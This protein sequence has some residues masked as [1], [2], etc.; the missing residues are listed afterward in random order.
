[1][2]Q[3]TNV[4]SMLIAAIAAWIFGAIYYTVFSKAWIAAR[5]ETMESMKAK[6]AGKSGLAKAAPFIISFIA[7]ILMAGALQGI[8]FHSAMN[9]VRQGIIAGALIWLGFVVTTLGVNNAYQGHTLKHT[10][11]DLGHWLGVLIIIGAIIGW[12]A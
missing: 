2:L 9:T 7:E 1:M 5:G 8:L 4:T 6:M 10:A 3:P 12:G 11:I